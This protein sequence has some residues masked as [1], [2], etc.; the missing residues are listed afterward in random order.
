MN[1]FRPHPGAAFE[2]Y[3]SKFVLPSGGSLA[4]IVC[5]VFDAK[6]RPHMVSFTYV[7]IK[8]EIYQREVWADAITYDSTSNGFIVKVSDM[9]TMVCSG[10]DVTYDLKCND[11]SLSGHT[12]GRVAWT[13]GVESSTPAGWYTYLPLPI[14]WHVHTLSS[15]AELSLSFNDI[16]PLDKT[17][18]SIVHI[19]KNWAQSF[20][21]SYIWIQGLDGDKGIC[22]AGGNAIGPL[23]AYLI[24]YRRGLETY[25]FKPPFTV[26]IAGISP[27]IRTERDLKR[28][29]M[30]LEAQSFTLKI[31]VDAKTD[32]SSFFTLSA[33]LPE[34]HRPKFCAQS[35]ESVIRVQVW[36]S[37]YGLGPW[38]Q[39]VDDTFT[40]GSLEF[41]GEYYTN[42][43]K[44]KTV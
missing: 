32:P 42:A 29:Y 9:G 4:L 36:K 37:W 28:G 12:S 3:Y 30:S 6:I 27:F 10:D 25:Q 1:Q 7:P 38:S 35:F 11:F 22:C 19:E 21:K 34:G 16:N 41:G 26:S 20:P 8:G 18:T 40:R 2:G 17:G 43:E 5:S 33:P 24:G 44:S 31:K 14:Q 23:E 15:K 13:P 39:V